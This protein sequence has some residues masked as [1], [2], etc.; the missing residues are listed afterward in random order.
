MK[1]F[2]HDLTSTFE[3][4]KELNDVLLDELQLLHSKTIL[5][6]TK[7]NNSGKGIQISQDDSNC[8]ENDVVMIR[9]VPEQETITDK[10]EFHVTEEQIQVQ[11]PLDVVDVKNQQPDQLITEQVFVESFQN[12]NEENETENNSIE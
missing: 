1:I 8:S 6:Q 3:S 12:E 11:K 9:L 4:S 10:V 7:A 5:D 2:F